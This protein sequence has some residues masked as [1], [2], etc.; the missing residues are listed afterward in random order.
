MIG[1]RMGTA[2][3]TRGRQWQT[4]SGKFAKKTVME[5]TTFNVE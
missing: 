5:N 4:T 3:K 1:E 2:G